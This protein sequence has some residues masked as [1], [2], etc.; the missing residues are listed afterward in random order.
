MECA[1]QLSRDRLPRA[2]QLD[3]EFDHGGESHSGQSS[4]AV[5]VTLWD[6][7]SFLVNHKRKENEEVIKEKVCRCQLV[8]E[9]GGTEEESGKCEISEE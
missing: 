1:M 3:Q 5:E 8:E 9:N 6:M 2:L 4:G 7:V